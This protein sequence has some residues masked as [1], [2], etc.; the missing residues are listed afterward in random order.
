MNISTD[1]TTCNNSL[2]VSPAVVFK[3]KGT[4]L[5]LIL[6]NDANSYY[7]FEGYPLEIWSSIH[8]KKNLSQIYGDIKSRDS[9]PDAFKEDFNN[10]VGFLIKENI[11]SLPP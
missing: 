9:L 1:F 5:T 8:D 3:I 2:P 10:F 4:E 7:K 11:L 6:M